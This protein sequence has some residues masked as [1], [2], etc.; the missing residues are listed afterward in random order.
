MSAPVVSGQQQQDRKYKIKKGARPIKREHNIM[1]RRFSD[2]NVGHGLIFYDQ[3][4]YI[5]FSETDDM[6]HVSLLRQ[7]FQQMDGNAFVVDI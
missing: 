3:H 1:R 2:A 7:V 5:L 6:Y 4:P